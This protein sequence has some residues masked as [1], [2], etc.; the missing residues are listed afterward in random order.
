MT[1]FVL[2]PPMNLHDQRQ[3]Y[4]QRVLLETAIAPNPF[5][6]FQAWYADAKQSGIKEPNAM[7]LATATLAGK[8]SARVVLLKEI[9]D[10]G[11]GFYTNYNSRKGQELAANP[12]AQLLFFWD[13][14]ERQIRIEGSIVRIDEAE[15]D[16]YFYSRPIV[17]QYGAM[18]S[19]QSAVIA[20]RAVLDQGL[21]RVKLAEPKRPA[22]WGGFLLIP[23]YFEFWQGR[24]SRLHDRLFYQAENNGWTRGRL[25]P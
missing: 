19:E 3:D 21:A 9:T 8:P 24:S 6:Q 14:M 12:Q 17:S 7:T 2:N 1:I 20:S 16:R 4:T 11:F 22:T 13:V 15:S 23:H 10:R 25:A 18:V 5:E